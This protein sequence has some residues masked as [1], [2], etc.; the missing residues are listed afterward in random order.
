MKVK[1]AIWILGCFLVGCAT[2]KTANETTSPI[3]ERTPSAQLAAK[4][5]YVNSASCQLRNSDIAAGIVQQMSA[6]SGFAVG[7]K[8]R[9]A[10]NDLSKPI[11]RPF[12]TD[13]CSSSPDGI[14]FTSNAS[15]LAECCVQHDTFYWLGGTVAEKTAADDHF[16]ACLSQVAAPAVGKFYRVFVEKFGGPDSSKTYRWGYGWN[17]RRPYG[18]VTRAE[19]EQLATLYGLN[20]ATYSSA[21]LA[22][23]QPME[24]ACG[25]NDT[26]FQEISRDEKMIYAYLNEHLKNPDQIE[27]AKKQYFNLQGTNYDFKLKGCEL[28]VAFK[29]LKSGALTVSQTCPGLLQ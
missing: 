10:A 19:E 9:I 15:A 22:L 16:Q 26:V 23:N 24:E 18:P 1:S 4:R 17:Y 6:L 27:W 2:S 5:A 21:L 25:S 12:S 8:A 11:L 20:R 3:S 7:P 29:I 13:G 14:P 28:P